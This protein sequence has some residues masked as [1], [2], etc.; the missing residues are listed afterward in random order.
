MQKWLS[1][2]ILNPCEYNQ[3]SLVLADSYT[4]LYQSTLQRRNRLL[5]IA[6]V[7]CMIALGGG[8]TTAV[9]YQQTGEM[10]NLHIGLLVAS[11]V[12]LIAGFILG[13]IGFQTPMPQVHEVSKLY[14]QYKSF[15]FDA[16]ATCLCDTR[17]T[18]GRAETL[19][20]FELPGADILGKLNEMNSNLLTLDEEADCLQDF[21]EVRR[22]I[23]EIE[24][25]S[26]PSPFIPVDDPSYSELCLLGEKMVPIQTSDLHLLPAEAHGL[27]NMGE[28]IDGCRTFALNRS[29][30]DEFLR[31]SNAIIKEH[32]QNAH[33]SIVS[34]WPVAK[35]DMTSEL[36]PKIDGQIAGL[37]GFDVIRSS[38]SEMFHTTLKALEEDIRPQINRINDERYRRIDVAEERCNMTVQQIEMNRD[39]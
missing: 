9:L 32:A 30:Y 26:I 38:T 35:S 25:R 1:S 4:K 18:E 39:M 31:T 37:S 28:I 33:Q 34:A 8:I 15:P 14:W 2:I 10:E 19:S 13:W 24:H 16:N 36:T 5:L 3:L 7:C 21:A 29:A 23:Q 27:D 20:L 12:S 6:S 11:G 22:K 17:K